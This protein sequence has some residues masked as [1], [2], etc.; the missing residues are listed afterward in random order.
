MRPLRVSCA[1][2]V[3]AGSTTFEEVMSVLQL[4]RARA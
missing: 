4:E 1:A 3:A 2:K